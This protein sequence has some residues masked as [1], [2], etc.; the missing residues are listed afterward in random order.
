MTRVRG[1]ARAV[2]LPAKGSRMASLYVYA[3]VDR[4]LPPAVLRGHEIRA[5]KVGGVYAAVEM[6]RC[7]PPVSEAALC[8]QHEIVVEL[9]AR[10]D[11][12]LPA[13]F[14][15]L[16]ER[17]ELARIVTRRHRQLTAALELVRGREQMTVRLIGGAAGHPPTPARQRSG[18]SGPGTRYLEQRRAAAG[19]PLPDVVE[20][21]TDAVRPLIVSDK[22]EPGPAGVRA[23]VYHLIERGSS[24]RYRRALE[25]ASA[26]SAPFVVK[27]TGPW[28]PFAF[29][30]EVFG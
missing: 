11:A 24:A 7:A 8:E 28:P 5:V 4:N 18:A 6:T 19:Y 21:L 23:T 13:R 27:V 30:P 3:L 15:S 29:A 26:G 14:G 10:A 17:D 20:R 9:A 22:A 12:I 25:A 16:L 2:C 1:S